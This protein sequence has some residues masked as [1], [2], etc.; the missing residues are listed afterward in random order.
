MNRSGVS[1]AF[2]M[3]TALVVGDDIVGVINGIGVTHTA[4][5]HRYID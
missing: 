2:E 5:I 4:L 1:G 3:Q